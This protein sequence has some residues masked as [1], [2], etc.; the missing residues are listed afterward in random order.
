MFVG[1]ISVADVDL[2]RPYRFR[3]VCN[4]KYFLDSHACRSEGGNLAKTSSYVRLMTIPVD[5]IRDPHKIH[6][7]YNF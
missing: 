2:C 3:K 4:A 1:Y 5:E 7:E 6:S